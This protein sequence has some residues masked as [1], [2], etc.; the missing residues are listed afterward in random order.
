MKKILL[1]ITAL[2]ICFSCSLFA[3]KAGEKAKNATQK[4]SDKTAKVA[5][6]V[7]ETANNVNN[8][9]N[10]VKTILRVFDPF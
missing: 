4:V 10:N 2:F 3:Q 6:D 1:T 9:V 8:T 5:A 7:Q